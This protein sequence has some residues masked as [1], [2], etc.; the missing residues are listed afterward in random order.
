MTTS[1]A[2]ATSLPPTSSKGKGPKRGVSLYSYEGEYEVSMTL[3]DCFADMY[4]MDA[5]GLEILASGHI[6]GY[7]NPTDEWIENWFALLK[8]YQI[9]PVEY[10]H[11]VD[12]RRHEGR[13]LTSKESFDM[14]VRDI[15][16]A[17][18]LGFKIGRTKLGVID[19]ILTPV[20]NWQEFIKMA[21]PVAEEYDFKMCPEIHMPTVLKSKMVDDYV[22]FIVKTGTKNFGLNIDFGVFAKRDARMQIPGMG[23]EI[24]EPEDI[25]PL[26]PYVYACHAKF[27]NMS[28]DLIETNIPYDRILKIMKDK[29]WDGY[30][31]SEYEGK[32]KAVPGYASDQLRRQHVMMKR[33]LGEA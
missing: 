31:L 19:E 12:S 32:D 15:K 16:L 1:A 33:Y 5:E 26:L 29:N 24:S 4:D 13:E 10:G 17:N 9:V 21:L 25:I 27:S 7:P 23:N 11:W 18:K 22:D 3:E 20:K 28:D 30:L 2:T 14:I 8:K 6:P